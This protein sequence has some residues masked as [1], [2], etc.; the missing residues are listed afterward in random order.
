MGFLP[1]AAQE[2]PRRAARILLDNLR[3]AGNGPGNAVDL[4]VLVVDRA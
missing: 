1:G 4:V 2:L 3:R